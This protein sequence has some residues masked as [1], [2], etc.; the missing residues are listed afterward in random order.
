MLPPESDLS[1]PARM[2]ISE[3]LPVPLGAMSAILSPSFM[4]KAM[5]SKRTLGPYDLEMFST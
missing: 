4:L 1:S 3:V 2:R 5:F